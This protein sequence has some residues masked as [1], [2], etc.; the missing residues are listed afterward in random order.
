[1]ERCRRPAG[2][3]HHEIAAHGLEPFGGGQVNPSAQVVRTLVRDGASGVALHYKNYYR[4]STR[5]CLSED[6]RSCVCRTKFV[7]Q[8]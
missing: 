7:V 6:G 4:N 3:Q 8:L 1:M 5:E 2:D